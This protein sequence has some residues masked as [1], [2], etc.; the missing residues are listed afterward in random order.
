MKTKVTTPRISRRDNAL[1]EKLLNMMQEL[2][3]SHLR[4]T[5]AWTKGKKDA[6][7]QAKDAYGKLACDIIRVIENWDAGKAGE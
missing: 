5:L 1:R 3:K 7:D 6:I 4:E 2:G